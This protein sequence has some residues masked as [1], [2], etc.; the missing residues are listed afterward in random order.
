[1][2][3]LMQQIDEI[4]KGPSFVHKDWQKNNNIS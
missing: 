2:P 4:R 1:L 3:S